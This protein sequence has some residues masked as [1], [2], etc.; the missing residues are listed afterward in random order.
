MLR[1]LPLLGLTLLLVACEAGDEQ[2]R[3]RPLENVRIDASALAADIAMRE[4][5]DELSAALR[6]LDEVLRRWRTLHP[7][8]ALPDLRLVPTDPDADASRAEGAED[9][10]SPGELEVSIPLPSEGVALRRGI[11]TRVVVELARRETARPPLLPAPFPHFAPGRNTNLERAVRL[12]AADLLAELATGRHPAPELQDW[13]TPREEELWDAFAPGQQRT[14][15]PL[16]G[17]DPDDTPPPGDPARYLGYRIALSFWERS[18]ERRAAVEELVALRD[19]E[20][21]LAQSGYE[22]PVSTPHLPPSLRGLPLANWPGFD[23]AM[24]AL[25]GPRIR[26]CTGG[27]G[28]IPVLLEAAG[29]ADLRLRHRLAPALAED[30]RVVTYDRAGMGGSEPTEAPRTPDRLAHEMAAALEVAAGP[31]PYVLAGTDTAAP[32]LEAFRTLYPWRTAEV[33]QVEGPSDPSG[34]T[35]RQHLAEMTLRLARA[36]DTPAQGMSSPGMAG[37]PSGCW[38][39][40]PPLEGLVSAPG[41]VRLGLLATGARDGAP[42]THPLLSPLGHE[43]GGR[44]RPGGRGRIQLLLGP[45]GEGELTRSGD[46]TWQGTFTPRGGGARSLTLRQAPCGLPD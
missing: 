21:F 42:G 31:G 46:G 24:V 26:V 32:T 1:L 41:P 40:E 17:G 37:E 8:A 13:A 9:P 43:V 28:Q 16:W 29:E 20:D 3:S 30:V 34:D 35:A 25:G 33:I 4:H 19:A 44:W 10:A 36:A 39:A 14:R 5:S 11:P 22:G 38:R 7:S 2:L 18:A 6:T 12:G 45:A 27:Q 23:C 15:P